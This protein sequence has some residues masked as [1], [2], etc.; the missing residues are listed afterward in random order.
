MRANKAKK[1]H[2]EFPLHKNQAPDQQFCASLNITIVK[3]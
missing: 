2:F 3:Q 1:D